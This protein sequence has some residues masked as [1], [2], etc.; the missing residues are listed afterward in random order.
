MFASAA[1]LIPEYPVSGVLDKLNAGSCVLHVL[2]GSEE[3]R[4]GIWT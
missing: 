3:A 1:P 4:L 2:L